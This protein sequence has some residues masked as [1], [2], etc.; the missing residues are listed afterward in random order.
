MRSSFDSFVLF[1]VKRFCTS[2]KALSITIPR[3]Q[4]LRLDKI[5][6]LIRPSGRATFSLVTTAI[7]S[8]SR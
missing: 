4:E 3:L 8:T 2:A 1:V 5:G 7:A 6:D